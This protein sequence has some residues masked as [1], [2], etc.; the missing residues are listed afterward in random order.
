MN[1]DAEKQKYIVHADASIEEAWSKIEINRH[2][3][4]IVTE[5]EKAVGTLSD[6]DIRKAIMSQR[7]L[8]T[9]VREVMNTNFRSLTPGMITNAAALFEERD[10]FLLPV[11]NEQMVLLDVIAR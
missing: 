3:S 1:L 9:P 8:T 10:I 6:G 7:L 4:V 2:R 11:V 5:N